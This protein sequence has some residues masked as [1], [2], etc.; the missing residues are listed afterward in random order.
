MGKTL[1]IAVLL[2]FIFFFGLDSIGQDYLPSSTTNQLVEHTHYT[3]SYFES[4]KQAEWVV[5]KLTNVILTNIS[6]A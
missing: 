1:K 4:H 6:V 2:L 3:V 5:Y